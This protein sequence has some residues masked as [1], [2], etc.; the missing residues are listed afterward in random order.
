MKYKTLILF[1]LLAITCIRCTKEN[2]DFKNTI[3]QSLSLA[4][5]QYLEMEKNVPDD[6]L[7]RSTAPDSSLWLS[8]TDW[9]TSGFYPGSLWYLYEFSNNNE[10]FNIAKKR[11]KT[12]EDQ[13]YFTRDHDI[14]FQMNCS[15][16]N[17]LRITQDTSYISYLVNS[18]I[19]LSTRFD[20]TVGCIRSWG[21]IDDQR[22]FMV[23]VDNMMNLELL[24][25]VTELTGDSSFYNIAISHANTTLA[26][27]FREDG[28]S[29]HL[30]TYNPAD[31]SVL[32]KRTVQGYADSSAWA[33]GQ[34]WGLYGYALCYRFTQNPEYLAHAN[35]IANFLLDHPN[36]PEDKVPY[37][38]FDAPEI[39]EAKR[40]ASAGA[41]IASALLELS[42]YVNEDLR[43][44]Y[45]D[46]A[47]TILE[48]L[49]SNA[50]RSEMGENNN[51]LLKHSV[52]SLP[53][54][55]EVDVPLTYADYYYIEGLMR[56]RKRL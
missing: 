16:G 7:P 23:I 24:F 51:F 13:Q 33:R 20:K 15:Y 49:S 37:W 40:D 26:N 3:D 48:S 6:M 18:A 22:R 53:G 56:L 38:D 32:S 52:G 46:A 55:S 39:P 19:S 54:N 44:K 5:Q 4:T 12:I 31:G 47:K 35:K 8:N 45:F 9:W 43:Q 2:H 50:Y 41:I 11:L 14:G 21:G 27:H 17:A 25:K 10:L 36:L 30:V 34:S 28:S 1:T 29:Y 42:E